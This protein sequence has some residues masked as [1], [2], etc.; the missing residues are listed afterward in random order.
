MSRLLDIC[1]PLLLK[2]VAGALGGG[3]H[4]VCRI[5]TKFMMAAFKVWRVAAAPV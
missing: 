3:D 1:S 5:F 4:L 2:H